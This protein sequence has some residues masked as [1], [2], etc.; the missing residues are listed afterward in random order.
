MEQGMQATAVACSNVALVKYWGKRD[1]ELNL[2]AVGSISL[3]LRDLTSRTRVR[4]SADLAKDELALDGRAAPES[5]PGVSKFLDLLRAEARVDWHALVESEN[6][7]P[8]G[9]GL[10]SSASGFAALAL[11][12][13]SALGLRLSPAALSALARRGSGS[14]ARSIFGGFVEMQVGHRP[15]GA[16]A[17][18]APLLEPAAWPLSVFVAVTTSSKKPVSSRHGMEQTQATSPYWQAWVDHAPQDLDLMRSAIARRD[19]AGLGELAEHS[20]L[21]MH[22][23]ALAARPGLLYW[24]PATVALMH[25]VRQLRR[26]GIAAYFTIDAGPQVKVLCESANAAS[27]REALASTPGVERL[28]ASGPGPGASLVEESM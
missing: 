24:N 22:A 2:P 6:S 20:C 5:L 9:A 7:F 18:A 11:A 1:A 17:I 14:A 27:V 23:L 26:D 15:D 4:F 10:A 16:D 19:F 21:K 13:S 28:I 25:A 8:T 12:A 3:T